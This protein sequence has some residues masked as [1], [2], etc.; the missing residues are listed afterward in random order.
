MA[1]VVV[2]TRGTSGIGRALARRFA[3]QGAKLAILSRDRN[4]LFSTAAEIVTLGAT[5]ALGIP[6]DV[7]DA[8]QLEVAT[9]R[10]EQELGPIDVWV[11]AQLPAA[12][13]RRRK[14]A[15][16]AG[17]AAALGVVVLAS[18]LIKRAA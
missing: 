5:A 15:W 8:Q 1:D 4:G 12:H 2:I 3:R 13:A 18:A 11:D 7:D 10:I 16:L 6:C 17:I 14:L 9:Q